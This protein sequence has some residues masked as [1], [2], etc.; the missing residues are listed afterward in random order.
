MKGGTMADGCDFCADRGFEEQILCD[1]NRS[2]QNTEKFKCR[3]FRSQPRVRLS[4]VKD[5]EGSPDNRE[6]WGA[7]FDKEALL[8]SD[9]FK[10]G[11]ALAVQRARNYPDTVHL[12]LKYHLAWN[13]ARRKPIFIRRDDIRAILDKAFCACGKQFGGF[14]SV[15]W[16]AP[17]HIH[18]YVESDGERS[19][20]AIAKELKRFSSS[21]LSVELSPEYL[22]PGKVRRIWDRAYFVETI[23]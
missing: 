22:C 17:D 7:A 6:S 21:V 23:G 3:A 14:A 13:V 8:G 18:V 20:E 1:L 2:A 4:T 19:L 9:R 16:L 5:I 12:D 15:L 10:Y 11:Q